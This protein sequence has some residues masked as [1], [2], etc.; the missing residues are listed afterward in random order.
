MKKLALTA[1]CTLAVVGLALA[2]D[3][4][5]RISKIS[6]DGTTV[7]GT[8]IAKAGKGNKGN[9]GKGGEEVTVKIAS[10][11]QVFK[12]KFD[13]EAKAF[14]KEGDDLKLSGLKSAVMAAEHGSVTV[15]N[16]SLTDKDILEL[17]VK[18]GKPSAKLNGS[19]VDMEN[20]KVAAKG[21]LTT[22]VT[23]DDSGTITSVIIGGGFGGGGKKKAGN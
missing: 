5:L 10:G 13:A 4:G 17:T 3:Y 18:D 14:V 6:D 20:V 23:T 16:K 7:T 11:V 22:Q 19:P 9:F 1:I 8:K 12:G 21:P 15:S 2:E